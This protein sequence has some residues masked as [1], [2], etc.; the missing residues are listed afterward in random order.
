[1][2]KKEI[3]DN[4]A[5]V[6]FLLFFLLAIHLLCNLLSSGPGDD[7][8]NNGEAFKPSSSALTAFQKITLGVPI[9]IN[10]ESLEGLTA[11]PGIGPGIA[12]S[13]TRERAKRNGFKKLDEIKSIKGI[14]PGLY[15]RVKPYLIL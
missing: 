9:S 2:M 1:M 7:V 5:G 11:V 6:L 3:N 12:R 13:I 8:F 15:G 10:Q 4:F 14:G